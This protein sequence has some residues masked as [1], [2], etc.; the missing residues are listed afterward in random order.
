MNKYRVKPG[1]HIKLAELDPSDKS[2][3][4]GDKLTARAVVKEL[5]DEMD[6]LQER[7]YAEGRR[8]VLFV[9]QA[10]DT[11]GKDGTIRSVFGELN[12]AGCRVASFKAPSSNELAHDYLWRI[13]AA[14]PRRGE[15][16]IFNRSQY[17]DVL[18]VRVHHLVER[19]VW[20]R[21][22][23]HINEFE[24]MLT[25]E[26][27]TI[28]KFFLHISKDEQKKR[29]EERLAEPTKH[30][31]FNVSDVKERALWDDYQKAYQ[32]MLNRTSTDY[33]PWYVVPAN[34]NWYRNL[35]VAR[36]AHGAL[37]KLNP[38]Y[39]EAQADLS[40]VVIE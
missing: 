33:A 18:V 19:K 27:T 38:Q 15:I 4:E 30:W 3:F 32:E 22:Y 31:K 35:V 14:L 6:E 36:I 7:L 40:Q 28:V 34:R 16:G 8:S 25:D 10:P 12:P 9:L 21:R 1:E 29:L 2:E 26:G 5:T 39:P 11:G 13:H 23:D 24:R 17:E 20:E 37:K